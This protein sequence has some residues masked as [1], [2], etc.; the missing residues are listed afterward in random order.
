M[1]ALA[2]SRRFASVLLAALAFLPVILAAE[3]IVW[4]P[5]ALA[6]LKVDGRQAKFWNVYVAHKKEH[7]ILVQLGRRNLVLD[8]ELRAVME[9]PSTAL[10]RRGKDLEWERAGEANTDNTEAQ[11]T[12]SKD[13]ER[14]LATAD[15][16][17]RDAGRARIIRARLSEEGRVL[18]VQLPLRPDQ[19]IL[20]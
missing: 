4:K 3:K 14:A 19:R 20:Y 7:L 13:E 15:W 5:V 6:L 1:N 12:R 17:I 2:C 11:S 8:T 9:I 10:Q 18:E 16:W